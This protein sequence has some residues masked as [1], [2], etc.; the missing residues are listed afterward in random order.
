MNNIEEKE[1]LDSDFKFDEKI[2]SVCI[3]ILLLLHSYGEFY[4][5]ESI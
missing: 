4:M 3:A 5:S 1:A 2:K